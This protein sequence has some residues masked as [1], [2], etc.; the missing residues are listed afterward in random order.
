MRLALVSV[1]ALAI[2]TLGCDDGDPEGGGPTAGDTGAVNEDAASPPANPLDGIGAVQLLNG[3]YQ[4]LEGPHWRAADGVLLFTD[5]PANT[6]YRFTPPG[7]FDTFRDGS[8]NANGLASLPDGR[9]LAAEHGGRRV[10]VT[11]SS[12]EITDFAATD[13]MGRTFNSPNDIA[14][15]SDGT[16]YFT[17]PPYGLMG[18][19]QEIPFFGVYRVAV[20]GEVTVEWMSTDDGQRPNGV[21]LNPDESVLYVTDTTDAVVRRFDVAADGSTGGEATF[22]DGV[23]GADGMAVD[24]AGNL[25]VTTSTGVQVFAPDGTRWGTIDVPEVPANCGFGGADL[26]TLFITAREGLYQVQLTIPGRP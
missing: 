12:G 13:A 20:G 11:A 21:A 18:R 7:S 5:I 19:A 22:T 26:R 8:Q 6:I 25:F 9:L 24:S 3:G 2:S 15:R 4:F 23:E 17:D 16:V 1:L 10:S 14:V